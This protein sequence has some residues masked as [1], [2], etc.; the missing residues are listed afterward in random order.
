MVSTDCEPQTQTGIY[1][2]GDLPGK[3]TCDVMYRFITGAGIGST[4]RSTSNAMGVEREVSLRSRPQA[5]GPGRLGYRERKGSVLD[6]H[7]AF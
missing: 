3:C 1:R 6:I 4:P 7:I 2:M 5:T